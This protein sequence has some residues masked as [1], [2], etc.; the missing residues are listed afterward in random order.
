MSEG[1]FKVGEIAIGHSFLFHTE[2]NEMECEVLM[3]LDNYPVTNMQ[4]MKTVMMYGGY[5]VRWADGQELYVKH[6]HLKRRK[7][8]TPYKDFDTVVSWENMPWKPAELEVPA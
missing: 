3:P 6:S 8:P 5:F 1:I 7:P 4:T 2:K